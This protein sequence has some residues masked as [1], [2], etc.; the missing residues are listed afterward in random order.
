MQLPLMIGTI[1]QLLD[2]LPNIQVWI[3]D[4]QGKYRWVNRSF[5]LNYSIERVEDVVGKTDY[6]FSP[7]HIADQVRAD[8][9]IVLKGRAIRR[10]IELVGR[11][12]HTVCW[13]VT[14]KLPLKNARGRIV[15]TI[16][17]THPLSLADV[18]MDSSDSAIGKAIELVRRNITKSLSNKTLAEASGMSVRGFE[19]KFRRCFNVSPQEYVR[20]IRIRMACCELVHT[21]QSLAAIAAVCG[22]CDQSHF[23]REFRRQTGVS[24]RQY[25]AQHQIR[26]H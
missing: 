19:R 3:K 1:L 4:R 11:F 10:R 25:R 16:G 20:R 22:F 2:F 24:P 26:N 8:D 6:D 15:A 17:L 13:N 23:S 14:N 9:E 18:H 7:W 5:L 12:D 21:G